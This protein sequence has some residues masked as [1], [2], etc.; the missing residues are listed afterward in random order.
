MTHTPIETTYS[1]WVAEAP[2]WRGLPHR[3]KIV[4]RPEGTWDDFIRLAPN[5]DL[6]SYVVDAIPRGCSAKLE[7]FSE[8]HH[9]AAMF[10]IVTD[11]IVDGQIFD[12]SLSIA[13]QE[14][15]RRWIAALARGMGDSRWARTVVGAAMHAWKKGTDLE[16]QQLRGSQSWDGWASSVVL[17]LQWVSSTAVAMLDSVGAS[18]AAR[19][20]GRTYDLFMLALQVIDDRADRVEDELQRGRAFSI[21]DGCR[22]SRALPSILLS[23]AATTAANSGL[24]TLG[25]WLRDFSAMLS[26]PTRSS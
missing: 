12:R 20:L 11:R 1:A 22:D 25:A 24:S 7:T 19:G 13:R 6:P 8:A 4:S 5:R 18:A 9:C 26:I 17:R 21:V 10:G 3:L 15:L 2:A 23:Q 14:L 16:R